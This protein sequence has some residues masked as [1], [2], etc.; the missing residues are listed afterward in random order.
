MSALSW[1]HNAYYHRLLLG[2]LPR[3]CRRALDVGCG[4]GAF[5]VKLA[6][7]VGTVDA[8][9]RSPV[10]IEAARRATPSNVTCILGDVCT[11]A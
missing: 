6:Q 9:D 11:S 5:A 3:P 1:D 4:A 7:R 8:L 10:M 2:Q